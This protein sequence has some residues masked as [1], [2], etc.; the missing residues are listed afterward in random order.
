MSI[1]CVAESDQKGDLNGQDARWPH[2]QDG[3]ATTSLELASPFKIAR[4]GAL[5]IL[6]KY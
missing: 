3:C 2:S 4:N 5:A 1:D 6:E